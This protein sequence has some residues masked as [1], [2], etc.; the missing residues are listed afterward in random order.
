MDQGLVFLCFVGLGLIIVLCLTAGPSPLL[1]RLRIPWQCLP[2]TVPQASYPTRPFIASPVL[3]VPI[4][5][6]NPLSWLPL[7]PHTH[8]FSPIQVGC[9]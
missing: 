7:L 9:P 6:F 2:I 3:R 4:F 1:S 5:P 8:C